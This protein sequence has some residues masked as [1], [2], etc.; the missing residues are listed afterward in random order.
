MPGSLLKTKQNSFLFGSGSV[1]IKMQIHF[2]G[3]LPDFSLSF[4]LS[5]GEIKVFKNESKWQKEDRALSPSSQR[6]D[7]VVQ[8]GKEVRRAL[9]KRFHLTAVETKVVSKRY[10]ISYFFCLFL[11]MQT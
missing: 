8:A 4:D 11:Y 3:A 1:Y 6:R 2:T 5:L 10:L 7:S 9:Y